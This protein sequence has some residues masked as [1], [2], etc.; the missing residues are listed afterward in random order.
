MGPP[1]S[2]HY[3]AQNPVI[4]RQTKVNVG[5]NIRPHP[6]TS[7]DFY[8]SFERITLTSTVKKVGF[9]PFGGD[10]TPLGI[11]LQKVVGMAGNLRWG[12]WTI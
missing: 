2:G 8:C 10:L 9:P 6:L 11:C 4:I 5:Q 1:T 7:Y 12:P 3:F